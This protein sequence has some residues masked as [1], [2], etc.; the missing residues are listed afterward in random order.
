MKQ[1]IPSQDAKTNL[2][3]ILRRV[4]AGEAFTITKRGKPVAELVPCKDARRLEIQATIDD[5]LKAQKK[6]F[7]SDEDLAAMREHGRK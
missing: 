6:H 7:V 5:M 4:E 1:E 3:S 2:P